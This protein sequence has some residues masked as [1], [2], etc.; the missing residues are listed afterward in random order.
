M[1]SSHFPA[2][3][4]VEVIT[5][6]RRR[7]EVLE[8]GGTGV[9]G[10]GKGFDDDGYGLLAVHDGSV[11]VKD[12]S[13]DVRAILGRLSA[14]S[15]GLRL[16]ADNGATALE[17]SDSAQ[18][19]EVLLRAVWNRGT[20]A[21][22]ALGSGSG[23]QVF[24]GSPGYKAWQDEIVITPN[25]AATGSGVNWRL[26]AINDASTHTVA[27]GS[28]PV[29]GFPQPVQM[30]GAVPYGIIGEPGELWAF[31]VDVQNTSGLARTL[32]VYVDEAG[33]PMSDFKL[34]GS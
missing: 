22:W 17:V 13:G 7:I 34:A 8:R 32:D 12:S 21:N 9:D 6:L 30:A 24:L 1:T 33:A 29:S 27:S 28:V 31:R 18:L 25:I 5:D 4:I 16:I 23:W 26:L 11:Q 15:Y 3:N 2:A 19:P 14:S 20:V 10:I